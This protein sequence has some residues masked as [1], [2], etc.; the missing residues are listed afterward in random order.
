MKGEFQ[1]GGGKIEFSKLDFEIPGA[2]LEM[3]GHYAFLADH[4]DFLGSV[5]LDA[6]VSQLFQ[7][8]KRCS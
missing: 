1:L 6:K 5:R 2:M 4:I 7:G 8:W 3:A